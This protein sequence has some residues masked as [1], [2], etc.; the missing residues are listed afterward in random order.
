M[1]PRNI[2]NDFA[3]KIVAGDYAAAFGMLA[4]DARQTWSPESIKRTYEDMIEYFQGS[5]AQVITDHDDE[6]GTTPLDEGTLVYVPI[7]CDDGFSEAVSVIIDANN[8][9]IEVEFGRP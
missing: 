6:Y 5:D 3:L 7:A 4:G 1:S 9:I 8:E 2:A